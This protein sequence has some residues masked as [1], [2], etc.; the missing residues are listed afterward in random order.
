MK[1]KR[2]LVGQNK[3]SDSLSSEASDP[4]NKRP[5]GEFDGM[6]RSASDSEK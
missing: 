2:A 5:R 6:E 1:E 3:S 4:G